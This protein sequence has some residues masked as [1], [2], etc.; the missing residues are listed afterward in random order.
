MSIFLRSL[1]TTCLV[2]T[3]RVLGA[4]SSLTRTETQRMMASNACATMFTWSCYCCNVLA[5]PEGVK[6]N[7]GNYVQLLWFMWEFILYDIIYYYSH[8]RMIRSVTYCGIVLQ[9]IWVPRM[10]FAKFQGKWDTICLY[11]LLLWQM[12]CF[13]NFRDW[14]FHE[15]RF[16]SVT[17]EVAPQIQAQRR[18]TFCLLGRPAVKCVHLKIKRALCKWALEWIQCSSIKSF[19]IGLR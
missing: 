8:S 12:R 1:P 15:T 14:V 17:S 7:Y 3:P 10:C 4:M 13:M 5:W 19:R 9:I 18:R 2:I 11:F 16:K 6:G